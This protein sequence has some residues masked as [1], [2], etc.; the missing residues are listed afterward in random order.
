MSVQVIPIGTLL[1]LKVG[2]IVFTITPLTYQQK[3]EIQSVGMKSGGATY[4]DATQALA[5]TIKYMIKDIKGIRDHKG[6]KFKLKFDG[7]FV[8]EDSISDIINLPNMGLLHRVTSNWALNGA[9]TN[10]E[11]IFG[12][13]IEGIEFVSKGKMPKK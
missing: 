9:T 2:D 1:D 13:S 11:E 5:L 8:S 12:E 10:L 6:N 7:D 4:E 3:A